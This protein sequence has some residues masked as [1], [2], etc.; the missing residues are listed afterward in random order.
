MPV[1]KIFEQFELLLLLSVRI[2]IRA[3]LDVRRSFDDSASIYKGKLSNSI[4]V[5]FLFWR[6]CH[7][8]DIVCVSLCVCVLLPL[9][10][11]KMIES[12]GFV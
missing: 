5:I 2:R 10:P 6:I 8:C 12:S 1:Q 4:L 3:Y 7:V 9:L 11:P